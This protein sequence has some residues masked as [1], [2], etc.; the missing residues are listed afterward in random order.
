M[1]LKLFT[2]NLQ[3]KVM[4]NDSNSNEH[5]I[6]FKKPSL[7]V[8]NLHPS[9]EVFY[10]AVEKDLYTLSDRI[11]KVKRGNLTLKQS[12]ALK[13]LMQDKNI[14]IRPADKGGPIVIFDT[15]DY[16]IRMKDM[17]NDDK[18]YAEIVLNDISCIINSVYNEL[19]ELYKMG[20]IDYNLYD[21]LLIEEPVIPII[22]G[23]PKIHKDPTNPPMRPI[24][25]GRGW[26]TENISFYLETT[27]KPLVYSQ[28]HIL[29]DTKEFLLD[30]YEIAKPLNNTMNLILVTMDVKSLFT[31]IPN[32]RG[33]E[34]IHLYLQKH[35][36]FSTGRI[37]LICGLLELIV[38]LAC[39]RKTDGETINLKIQLTKVLE[40]NSDLCI[41]FYNVVFRRVMKILDLKLVGRNFYDPTNA[42]VLQQYRLQVWPGYAASIRR[43]DG[44]LFLLAD[45]SHKVIRNDSVLDIMQAIFHQGKENFQDECTKQLLGNIIITRYNNRTYRIDDIEWKKCPQDRFTMSDG[46]SI[47]FLEYYRTNYGITIK[48]KEQPLLVHRP[49]AKVGPKGEVLKGEILLLPEL[50]FMTGIPDK[51]RKDFRAMKDLT[52]QIN[53]SPEQHHISLMKLLMNINKCEAARN[54]L[55]RWGLIVDEDIYKTEGRVLPAEKINFRESSFITNQEADW[56]RE[57]GREISISTIP[58]NFWVLFYPKRCLDQA[59][60][61]INVLVKIAGPVGMQV[62]QPACVELKDDRVE[63][64]IRSIRTHLG[65][66]GRFQMV[67]CIITG[68]RDDLYSAIKKL[69]CVQ[70]PVPS[71]VINARTVSQPN[72]L[73]SIAQKILLQ[74]NCKMGGELWGVD[75]PLK[76]LMVIGVDVYHDPSRG[77]RS[78]LGFAAS[79]NSTLTRWYSRVV[80]QLPQQEIMDSLKL[81]FLSSL[82]KYY[83]VNHCLPDKIAVY[84]DGVSDGQLTTVAEYEV[85][86]LQKCFETFVNYHPRM[87]VMVVQKRVSTNLYLA[88]GGRLETPPPGTILDHTVTKRNW[89]DFYLLAHHVRQGCGIP[90]HYICVL[91]TANL[92]PDHLQRLTYK[93]CHMYWNW[94]GTIR[95]PAPCKYAHKLA[96][97]AGQVLHHEPAMQLCEKLFFL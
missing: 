26:V 94:P 86:Q 41:P 12:R 47:T 11:N 38:N 43:T 58:M 64:Y 34:S 88:E 77:M 25:S 9:I 79:M 19:E 72:R 40:P 54:E 95:V 14:S 10:K 3:L 50:S 55:G 20:I 48:E 53:L 31:N 83:E 17:L 75:I 59:R 89:I 24:V 57:I 27:L 96:F 2:R 81:C 5:T 51:M 92:S 23:L 68:N 45:V 32:D 36:N 18:Y 71:Q 93:L 66:E 63:S 85:P 67:V 16:T 65:S 56:N 84:R 28:N 70:S 7:M 62:G 42:T 60:E 30:F 69:C 46:K 33:L 37:D 21:Y 15:S 39:Q 73:R 4:F 91:N 6:K 44:G 82:Q 13:N 90:T 61:L 29:K 80:F 35:S 74:I 1:D 76:Q 97:L 52:Q 78:V 8:P 87:V 22:K 49:K